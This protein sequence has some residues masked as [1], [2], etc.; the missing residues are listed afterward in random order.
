[1]LKVERIILKGFTGMGLHEIETFDFTL[2]SDVTIILGGNGSGKTSL[3]KVFFPLAPPKTEFSDGG[4]YTNI[5]RCG[6]DRYEFKVKR[7]GNSLVCF[8]KNLTKD[9]IVLD[10]ANAKL[11]NS[12]V[13][14]LTGLDK[15]VKELINGES[16]LTNGNTEQRRKWFT[17]MSTSDL[18]YALDFYK[19]LRKQSSLLNGAIDHTGKKMADLQVRVVEDAGERE[20]LSTRLST[21]EKELRHYD[22]MLAE[23][24]KHN[25]EANLSRIVAFL[26]NI[27]SQVAKILSVERL[28]SEHDVRQLEH[29]LST[30][31]E[32][33]ASADA[34]V[35]TYNKELSILMDESSRQEYL[36][37]NHTGLKDTIDG[38]E[39]T[40]SEYGVDT[41]RWSELPSSEEMT[42]GM[43]QNALKESRSW[44]VS[45][46][47]S[48]DEITR[49]TRLR[50]A[51]AVLAEH[52]AVSADLNTRLQRT[53]NLLQQHEHDRSH[54]LDT[55][56]VNCPRCNNTFRPGINDSLPNI[57]ATIAKDHEY[58][59]LLTEKLDVHMS[60]RADIELDVVAKRRIR[61]IIMT[62]AKDPVVGVFFKSLIEEEV[63]TVNRDRY[64]SMANRFFEELSLSIQYR[65]NVSLLAKARKDWE[66][67]INAVG[68]I[69]GALN[70]KIERIRRE[71]NEESQ[72]RSEAQREVERLRGELARLNDI[73]T[74]M[75][76]LT[77]SFGTLETLTAS[78]EAN[79]VIEALQSRRGTLLDTYAVARDRFRQMDSE[80]KTL[81][82]LEAEMDEL[83]KR[84]RNIRLMITAWSPE[85]GVLRKHIYNS[86]VRI[87]EM[88]NRYIDSVWQYPM[89]VLPCDVSEGDL[90]YTFPYLLKNK[91]EPVPDVCKG[92]K[93]QQNI[94]N[95]SFRL[96][97][98]RGLG[99][100]QYPLL[101]DEPSEG[102][103]EEHKSALV[104]FI[105][106]LSESGEFSQVIVVSHEPEVHSKLNEATYC[107]IE[108]TGVTLPPVYNVGVKIKYA[109]DNV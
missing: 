70:A 59:N 84:Q 44:S 41:Y 77:R 83:R 20:V 31:K 101:L 71:L 25:A 68:N 54:F 42:V 81:A 46:S 85:K 14:E 11:Y 98:Y 48:L 36:M 58:I 61:D 108:P 97:S 13:Y 87:T 94:F 15:E 106:M 50:E 93:A 80:M 12:H 16:L 72:R 30:W 79:V 24:P 18:A 40:L 35:S 32:S 3:L 99:L 47:G 10:H 7:Q 105:K 60:T 88:M 89:N 17:R 2:M 92:S 6:D 64:G 66:E 74:T 96:T 21:M 33:S 104:K 103:D 95:L 5:A 100:R 29:A 4:S 56:E 23:L 53:K 8:I 39:K 26:K 63:F 51:E 9:V 76:F 34:A 69:D 73:R 109:G 102:L 75:D 22:D 78:S 43:L 91:E 28:P 52:D 107:V 82:G 86:V 37:R 38:L 1:M 19:K 62:Y 57:E 55:Q 65:H 90:D 27:E 49:P 45:L 67:A